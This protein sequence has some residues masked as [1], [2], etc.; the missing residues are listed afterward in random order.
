MQATKGNDGFLRRQQF[1]LYGLYELPFGKNKMF[2]SHVGA[3]T[4]QII[5][6][7]QLSPSFELLQWFAVYANPW[8][9]SGDSGLGSLL[10]EWRPDA[11]PA[12][13]HRRPVHY[14]PLL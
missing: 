14:P 9:M 3:V 7:W 5:G 4:N 8:R 13:D 6:G 10:H 1:I 11:V 2:G 12:P